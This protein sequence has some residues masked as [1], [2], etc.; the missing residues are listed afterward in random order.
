[1]ASLKP[2]YDAFLFAYGASKDK[3]LGIPG[4]DLSGIYSARA[5]VGWYNGLPEYSKLDP[6]LDIGE[7]V[8]VIGQ[9]NVALDVARILL[10]DVDALRSTDITEHALEAL[11]KSRVK[12]VRV[13]GRRGPMQAAYTIK[14][15]RE[16][17][18]LPSVSFT[19]IEPS[20]L[21]EDISKLPRPRKRM[22][23]VLKK[24]STA[25]LSSAGKKWSLDYF[26]LPTAFNSSPEHPS[27]I[28]T[29][30]FQHTQFTASADPLD[31][32]AR[33][34]PTDVAETIPASIAFRSVGYK[35][36]ALPGLQDL[37]VSFDD[38]RG[39]I[40]NDVYGR[41]IRPASA[42]P[43]RLLA[44]LVPGMYC[45]GWVKKGPTGVIASTMMDAFSSADALAQ[46]WERG[47]VPFL[48]S[49]TGG[50]SGLGWDGVKDEADDKGLRRVSW[51]NWRAIDAA[52]RAKGQ[53][54][55]KERE[56]FTSVDEMLKVLD[57]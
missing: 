54:L 50:S 22:L 27:R 34:E 52:E 16:L 36:S 12:S 47:V 49:E 32:A 8:A 7:D 28:E 11:L 21:P 29:V 6:K 44:S 13:V 26:R 48:N 46:D 40:P 51:E 42:G 38:R 3:E 18:H 1:L 24:G 19:P 20:L 9:G 25:D 41:V 30:T 5:F 57:K 56:K 53:A 14:E 55:G 39:I 33:V 10:T 17:M 35:S 45:A 31:P 4:E 43:E 23:E 15:V 2:H 37:G